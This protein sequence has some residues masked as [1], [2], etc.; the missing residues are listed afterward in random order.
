MSDS[1]V[2]MNVL[3]DTRVALQEQIDRLKKETGSVVRVKDC[4]PGRYYRL[5]QHQVALFHTYAL[6]YGVFQVGE[7]ALQR[8]PHD[9]LVSVDASEEI[10]VLEDILARPAHY[11]EAGFRITRIMKKRLEQANKEIEVVQ[12]LAAKEPRLTCPEIVVGRFTALRHLAEAAILLA[13][14]NV[15][16]QKVLAELGLEGFSDR[17]LEYLHWRVNVEHLDEVM[18][19]VHSFTAPGVAVIRIPFVK[20]WALPFSS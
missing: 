9:G 1:P 11:A 6:N 14:A 4:T 3:R 10:K 5:P 12:A 18:A 19:G 17:E 2:P 7:E 8:L 16:S 13:E 15:E 20:P